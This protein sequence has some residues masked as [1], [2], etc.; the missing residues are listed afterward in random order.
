ME[1]IKVNYVAG[2]PAN[3]K[4]LRVTEKFK[5]LALKRNHVKDGG[6]YMD[7]HELPKYF[8]LRE[9]IKEKKVEKVAEEPKVAEIEKKP[10][11]RTRKKKE[12]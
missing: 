4:K 6:H 3:P 9:E 1:I 11:R 2:K 7:V 10:L 12:D 5:S 8:T